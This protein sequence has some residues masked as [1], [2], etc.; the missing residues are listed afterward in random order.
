MKFKQKLKF[1]LPQKTITALAGK[2]AESRITWWKNFA[3][4]Y[5]IKRYHVDLKEALNEDIQS[6]PN[7][8]SFFTRFLKPELRPI[9]SGDQVIISPA[10]GSI[11]QIGK[12]RNDTLLQAKGSYYSLSALLGGHETASRHFYDGSYITIYLAPKDYHRVHMPLNGRLTETIY[13]PGKLFSVNPD[14]ARSI[15]QLFTRNERLVSLFETSIGLM[16]VI[17]VGAMIVRGI[18]TV[19]PLDLK[20]TRIDKQIYSENITLEKGNELGHFEAGSTVIVLFPKNT[21]QWAS[22]LTE[23]HKV[24]M[25]QVIGEIK[26]P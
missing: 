6:Y 17:M 8:N 7:F 22:R 16:A 11:S 5:F 15:P 3:I 23:N 4:H 12:I 2:L 10:D 14:S 20:Q 26:S 9:A 1:Y 13:V 25:G 18:K 19:W 21:V 24:Q